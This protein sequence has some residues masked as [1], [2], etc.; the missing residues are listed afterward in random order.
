MTPILSLPG[1]TRSN[2]VTASRPGTESH[3][4][5]ASLRSYF[6]HLTL[7]RSS[8]YSFFLLE[9]QLLSHRAAIQLWKISGHKSVGML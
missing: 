8:P 7:P 4:S 5:K 9:Q 1:W 3:S 2:V 6:P